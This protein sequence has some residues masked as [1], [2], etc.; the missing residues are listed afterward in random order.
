MLEF[1]GD[2]LGDM[3]GQYLPDFVGGG[4]GVEAG[5][6]IASPGETIDIYLK[7]VLERVEVSD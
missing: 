2:V 7:E 1:C 5:S 3:A 4:A 6:Q